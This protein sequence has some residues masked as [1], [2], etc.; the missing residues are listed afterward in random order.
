M[1]TRKIKSINYLVNRHRNTL[2][3]MV[4]YSGI[5][6]Y[7]Y[8]FQ[9]V[10]ELDITMAIS[11]VLGVSVSLLL[12]FR[13]G[14]AYDRWWEARKIWG[15]IVNDSRTWVRQLIGFVGKGQITDEIK[16][17]ANYQ[18]GWCYALK[19]S[20]RRLDPFN[21]IAEFISETD[22]QQ[23]RNESNTPNGILL[24][25]E[26]KIRWLFDQGKIDSYQYV[27]LDETLSRLCDSMG[28]C[29]RIKNTV[30]PT[31]YRTYTHRG[32]IILP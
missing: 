12:A 4:F 9:D 22:L 2:L 8:E 26:K 31:Q 25:M 16:E 20:L 13:T 21:E 10:E 15:A 27:A 3:F 1:Y 23:L 5:I 17:L 30:F 32:I 14:A 28:K 18:I 19:D 29:E 6:Y 7:F 11:T 24:I